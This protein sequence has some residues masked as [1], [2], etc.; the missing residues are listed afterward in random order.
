MNCPACH[1]SDTRV[2]ETRTSGDALRRR[3][4]CTGCGRRYTTYERH[5]RGPLVVR[6]R[7]GSASPFDRAKVQRGLIRAAHKRPI[8][9]GHLEAIV[10]RIES[11]LEG[12]GG[13]LPSTALGELAL[14]GLLLLDPVAY[15]RFASVYRDFDDVGELRDLLAQLDSDR[16]GGSAA[17]PLSVP[18]TSLASVRAADEADPLDPDPTPQEESR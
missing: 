8:D 1:T 9:P 16:L 13:E 17:N 7:D 11:E 10:D 15:V 4:E 6:K 2:I 5:E 14:A 3:R 18:V 12:A